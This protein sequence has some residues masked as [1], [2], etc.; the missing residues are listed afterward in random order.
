MAMQ[1]NPELRCDDRGNFQPLQC[2]KDEARRLYVCQCVEPATGSPVGSQVE[3]TERDE[4]PDTCDD[5]GKLSVVGSHCVHEH[6]LLFQ[7]QIKRGP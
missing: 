3:V 4:L 5:L 1:S 6:T 2:R 7:R